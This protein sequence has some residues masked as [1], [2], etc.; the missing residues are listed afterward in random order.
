MQVAEQMSL[1]HEVVMTLC[2]LPTGGPG[3]GGGDDSDLDS[4][5]SQDT[6]GEPKSR[7]PRYF[8]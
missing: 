4:S 6:D 1:A 8:A 3:G 5:D 2:S 7:G